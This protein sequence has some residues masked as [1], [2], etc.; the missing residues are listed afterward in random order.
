MYL[1]SDTDESNPSTKHPQYPCSWPQMDAF[2]YMPQ[3]VRLNIIYIDIC[4]L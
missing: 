4:A 1:A 2:E 3:M